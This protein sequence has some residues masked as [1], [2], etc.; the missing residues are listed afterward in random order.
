MDGLLFSG[1][2]CCLSLGSVNNFLISYLSLKSGTRPGYFYFLAKSHFQQ[3]YM[4]VKRLREAWPSLSNINYSHQTSLTYTVLV[5][6]FIYF[7]HYTSFC[8]ALI[9]TT[10]D[11]LLWVEIMCRLFWFPHC[12]GHDSL[13]PPIQGALFLTAIIALVPCYKLT[14]ISYTDLL[15]NRLWCQPGQQ[16]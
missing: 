13:P 7:F 8:F 9:A 4:A 5:V 14:S 2:L 11:I 10:A 15:F 6:S 16:R 12:L 3:K 1:R